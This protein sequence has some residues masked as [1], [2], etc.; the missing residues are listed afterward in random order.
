M[1]GQ[2]IGKHVAVAEG[3]VVGSHGGVAHSMPMSKTA[4]EV[5]LRA[6]VVVAV[7]AT[8]RNGGV[9]LY[10]EQRDGGRCGVLQQLCTGDATHVPDAAVKHSR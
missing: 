3:Q 8:M 9:V 5:V 10:S 6:L 7:G 4:A 1:R 2:R